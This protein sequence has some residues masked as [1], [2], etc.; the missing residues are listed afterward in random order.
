M[1]NLLFKRILC[2]YLTA[3]AGSSS[4]QREREE[5]APCGGGI[6]VWDSIPGSQGSS[7]E[8]R[9]TLNQLSYPD[10]LYICFKNISEITEMAIDR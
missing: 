7:P 2:I 10:T 1:C 4:R 6:P 5:Q 8:Q 9:Q 3:Q